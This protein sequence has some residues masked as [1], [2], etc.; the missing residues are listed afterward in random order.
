[1]ADQEQLNILKQGIE[2]WNQWRQKH[3]DTPPDLSD[4][5][6][7][8]ANLCDFYS[9][10][11]EIGEATLIGANLNGATFLILF[12]GSLYFVFPGLI[13]FSAIHSKT[14]FSPY[15]F[16]IVTFTTLGF[17]D[18]TAN[19]LLGEMVVSLQVILGY[20]TLG[21][22]ISILANKVARRRRLIHL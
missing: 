17:G 2:T 10:K 16:S 21:L 3:T 5:D 22:L 1:M 4:A 11:T 6:L 18:V 7:S 12:F 13:S 14:W 20:L 8:R 9:W 19:G 15:Y